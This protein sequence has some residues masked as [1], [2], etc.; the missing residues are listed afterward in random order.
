MAT[1]SMPRLSTKSGSQSLRL[2]GGTL[3]GLYAGRSDQGNGNRTLPD[4]H[5]SRLA[6]PI[7]DPG[8]VWL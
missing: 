2:T 6:V 7:I 4:P 3:T 1:I 8:K 5:G